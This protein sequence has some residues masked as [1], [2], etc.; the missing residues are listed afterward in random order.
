[1][2]MREGMFT[3]CNVVNSS[4][5]WEEHVIGRKLSWKEPWAWELPSEVHI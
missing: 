3:W 1:M 5:R 4:V 2:N